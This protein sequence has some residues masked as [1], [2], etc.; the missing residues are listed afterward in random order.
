MITSTTKAYIAGLVATIVCAAT[1]LAPIRALAQ[2]ATPATPAIYLVQFRPTTSEAERT[3]WLTDAGAVLV[4]WMP[5]ISV[6]KVQLDPNR[7]RASTADMTAVSFIENDAAVTGQHEVADAAFLEKD[8]GYGQRLV[9]VLPAWNVT[10]GISTTIVAVVDTGINITHTEFAGRLVAGY[11]FVNQDNDPTDDHGH[12]THIAGTIAAGLDG[13][14]TVGMCPHCSVMPVKV[15]NEK[16]AG[17]W[18]VVAKG[19]LFAVD[20]GARVINLSL[21]AAV[22]SATLESAVEY[23]RN[24]NVV[25]VAAAGNSASDRPFYP[26]AIPYVIAVSATNSNDQQW[27]LSNYGDYIDVVAPGHLIYGTYHDLSGTNGYAFMSGTS[28]AAPFVSG[29]AALVVSRQP[30]MT[31]DEIAA[32]IADHADDLG[33]PGKDVYFGSGRINAYATMVAANDNVKPAPD[34]TSGTIENPIDDP[35]VTHNIFLAMVTVAN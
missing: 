13:I 32:M 29:L 2:G 9:D 3:A 4:D 5:Q 10:S 33:D 14:G 7:M 21:G 1:L 22:S 19:I 25:V 11:D 35:A 24:N 12:G 23:A 34:D 8:K 6:A 20:H 27:P 16:N 17:M 18:S 30:G 15:L 31:G 28:M 26:A